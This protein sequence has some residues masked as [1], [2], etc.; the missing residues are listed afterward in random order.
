[1]SGETSV[2]QNAAFL[3]AL[4]ADLIDSGKALDTLHKLIAVSNRPEEAGA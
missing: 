2:T 3:A 1:M 4:A